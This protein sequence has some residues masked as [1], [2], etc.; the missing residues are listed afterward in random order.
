MATGGRNFEPAFL[1]ENPEQQEMRTEGAIKQAQASGMDVSD[2]EYYYNEGKSALDNGK[3]EKAS[4]DFRA[5]QLALGIPVE[6]GYAEVWEA[7]VPA[8][9]E[10]TAAANDSQ[11][12]Q[13]DTGMTSSNMSNA[14]SSNA[15]NGTNVVDARTFLRDGEQALQNGDQNQAQRDFRAAERALSMNETVRYPASPNK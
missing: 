6:V 10:Y 3:K 8:N 15:S 13:S 9:G 12:Q 7:E 4:R 1:G 2:A 11:T 5:A 14:M